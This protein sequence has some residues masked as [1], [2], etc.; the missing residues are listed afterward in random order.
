MKCAEVKPLLDLLID[1]ETDSF[2][3]AEIKN[4][5]QN[6]RSCQNALKNLQVISRTLKKPLPVSAS[7]N[8]DERVLRSFRIHQANK[9][10]PVTTETKNGFFG[11]IF[12]PVPVLALS[13]ALFALG[14]GAAYQ[15]GKTSAAKPD[16]ANEKISAPLPEKSIETPN[17]TQQTLIKYVEVPVTK[18]VKIPVVREKQVTKII[19]REKSGKT[20]PAPNL[21]KENEISADNDNDNQVLTQIN[22]SGF[23]PVSEL[24]IKVT[25]K[26]ESQ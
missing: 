13:F 23:Q 15:F 8:L 10:L 22:L 12:I 1:N 17:P 3:E 19:Y 6:C 2:Q 4:H 24:I 11:R 26:G 16:S 9:N 20:S 25:K 14:I 21:L 18:I 7:A 5:L